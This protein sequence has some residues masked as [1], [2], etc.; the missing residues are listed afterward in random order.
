[1]QDNGIKGLFEVTVKNVLWLVLVYVELLA[2]ALHDKLLDYIEKNCNHLNLV[3]D[4]INK[5][6]WL[7]IATIVVVA[8]PLIYLLWFEFDIKKSS[9]RRL[10]AFAITS[11]LFFCFVNEE[12]H[13]P[14]GQVIALTFAVYSVGLC[15]L[16]AVKFMWEDERAEPQRPD[17]EIKDLSGFSVISDTQT[18]SY[19]YI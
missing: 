16:E 10:I 14:C 8:I 7:A 18:V 13:L 1:M 6:L 19:R 3:L 11:V 4:A 17:Y 15:V 2:I 9:L 12:N 5:N